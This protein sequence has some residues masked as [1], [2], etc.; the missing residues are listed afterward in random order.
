MMD[1]NQGPAMPPELQALLGGGG[2]APAPA[3]GGPP[4]PEEASP[5]D[6]PADD[7][8]GYDI[9]QCLNDT[10]ESAKKCLELEVDEE[11]KLQITKV[12]QMLQQL[13]A[14]DQLMPFSRT[15]IPERLHRTGAFPI[16]ASLTQKVSKVEPAGT[17]ALSHSVA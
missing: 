5:A 7:Q 15:A 17:F 12:L 16:P 11:D 8:S 13:K 6:A 9:V 3:A 2:G 10:I 1:P 4:S 14:K